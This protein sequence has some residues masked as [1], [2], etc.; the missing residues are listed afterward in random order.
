MIR[1]EIPSNVEVKKKDVDLQNK[2]V[3]LGFD[4]EE[5]KK[6]KLI[7]NRNIFL[8]MTRGV[9]AIL[10]VMEMLKQ[11][12][13]EAMDE[14]PL[15]R[16]PCDAIKVKLVDAKLHEDAIHRGPAQVVP[17]VRSA[18]REAMISG[19]SYMLE[20]KQII[21]IDV[22]TDQLSGAMKEV[23][24]R[25]GQIHEMGE[26][27]GTTSITAKLPVAEMF[28][29]NSSLKSST[30]GQGFYWLI[31]VVYEPL[32]KDLSDKVIKQI[33]QRKGITD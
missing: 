17:T 21:R 30:G 13:G 28:G 24:N 16:E 33:K 1:G 18:V 15:A 32:P 25:R 8:D 6:V 29:F 26:E 5:S 14:G 2:L 10:E 31:D 4:R 22:P 9:H 19:K 7:H 20:P 27:R 3:D 11:A 12:F 23:Q